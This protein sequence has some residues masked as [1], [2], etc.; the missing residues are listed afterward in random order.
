MNSDSSTSEL[1][2]REALNCPLC[3][4]ARNTWQLFSEA[5][6]AQPFESRLF[7]IHVCREC[8]LGITDP[9]PSE[10]D[11]RL[12]YEARTSCDYQGDDSATASR[13]KQAIA[14]LDI[15]TFVG[16]IPPSDSVLKML[17]Y[18]CGN[19]AFALSMQ[20]VHP[21]S[22]VW[23]TDYH[24]EAPS[25]L[26]GSGVIYT[27]YRDLPAHGPF[28]FILCRHVLEHTYRPTEFLRTMSSLMVTGGRLMIE[29]P[30][31]RAPLRKVFGR[32]WDNYYVPYH[33]IHFSKASLARAVTDSGLVIERT[34]GCEM[35]KIGRSLR[36]MLHCKYNIALFG[37]GVLLHPFQWIAQEITSEPTCLRLWARKP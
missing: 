19:G 7:S 23:A 5:F 22:K 14:D 6:G 3:G 17:D 34:G 30:N 11:S 33:P 9:I 20:R 8:G 10:T 24:T 29:I 1:E 27:P 21:S 4:S 31:L 18:A 15:R 26:Q 36:N 2:F 12:L 37:T 13:L 25:T 16:T 32:H 35:P 28:D